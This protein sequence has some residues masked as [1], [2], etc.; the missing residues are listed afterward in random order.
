MTSKPINEIIE[1]LKAAQEKT[2]SFVDENTEWQVLGDEIVMSLPEKGLCAVASFEISEEAELCVLLRNSLP[3]ILAE[4]RRLRQQERWAFTVALEAA[5][6]KVEEAFSCFCD[7]DS[8]WAICE[9]R[10]GNELAQAI[11]A[12][13]EDGGKGEGA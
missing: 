8:H 12:L 2:K 1:E 9:A 10:T 6:R 11:R 5:A 4:L 3:Q 7:G 13:R